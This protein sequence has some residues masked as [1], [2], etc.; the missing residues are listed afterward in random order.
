MLSGCLTEK[1]RVSTKSP[2]QFDKKFIEASEENL[3][4]K[5]WTVTPSHITY[6]R[7]YLQKSL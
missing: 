4:V 1:I 2:N 7:Q 5:C 3:N 6:I